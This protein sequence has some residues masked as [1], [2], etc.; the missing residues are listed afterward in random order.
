MGSNPIEAL[1]FGGGGGVNL[2][3]LWDDLIFTKK[4]VF[5]EFTLSLSNVKSESFITWLHKNNLSL[6]VAQLLKH[7]P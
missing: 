1:K 3:L 6:W 4:F 5:L 7:R 2:Q